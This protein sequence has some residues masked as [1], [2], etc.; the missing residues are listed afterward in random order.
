[1]TPLLCNVPKWQNDFTTMERKEYNVRL[2][3]TNVQSYTE[4]I[5]FMKHK[6]YGYPNENG[7]SYY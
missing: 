2:P 3:S 7:S 5:S 4:Y 1:M 6:N